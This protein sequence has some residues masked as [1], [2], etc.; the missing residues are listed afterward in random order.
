MDEIDVLT[1]NWL[2]THD[3][4][5]SRS[6]IE[7]SAAVVMFRLEARMLKQNRELDRQAK[8]IS[9]LKIVLAGMYVG[10]WFVVLIRALS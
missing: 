8:E 7:A 5:V 6:V 9:G 1:P 4:S 2:A 10:I 3:G